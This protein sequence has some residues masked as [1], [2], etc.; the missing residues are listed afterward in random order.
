MCFIFSIFTLCK[1]VL[2]VESME[3]QWNEEENWRANWEKTKTQNAYNSSNLIFKTNKSILQQRNTKPSCT[4]TGTVN[5]G[6]LVT[7][8]SGEIK[9]HKICHKIEKTFQNGEKEETILNDPMANFQSNTNQIGIMYQNVSTFIN[10]FFTK[11]KAQ[12]KKYL[13]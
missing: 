5:I 3:L 7:Y 8:R 2:P 4:R 12:H 9:N 13:P 11:E 1:T 6:D 10:V